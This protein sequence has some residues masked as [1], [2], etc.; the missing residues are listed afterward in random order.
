LIEVKDTELTNKNLEKA[1]MSVAEGRKWLDRIIEEPGFH[2]EVWK[3]AFTQTFDQLEALET[4]SDK[5]AATLGIVYCEIVSTLIYQLADE[6]ENQISFSALRQMHYPCTLDN[7]R[8]LFKY[9]INDL[10]ER[11]EQEAIAK[12]QELANVTI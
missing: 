4:A 7:A 10:W 8:T 5:D 3:L 2:S 1:F 6:T 11:E 9:V 12:E